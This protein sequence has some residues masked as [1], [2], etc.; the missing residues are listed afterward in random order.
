MFSKV[1]FQPHSYLG[2]GCQAE[3]V[4]T[5][6]VTSTAIKWFL[7]ARIV[8]RHSAQAIMRGSRAA[9]QTPDPPTVT[10]ACKSVVVAGDCEEE[11]K[12]EIGAVPGE[13]NWMAM[14]EETQTG[15]W[16]EGVELAAM[17]GTGCCPPHFKAP[18]S[19][20]LLKT[21]AIKIGGVCLRPTG[22]P[23]LFTLK[24]PPHTHTHCWILCSPFW[25]G[26]IGM[27]GGVQDWAL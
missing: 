23:F 27:A 21:Y 2:L 15:R 7:M 13:G 6:D 5:V 14:E 10:R 18:H 9:A 26:C 3:Q 1:H 19:F 17:A 25:C 22:A 20:P 8:G 16:Q 12:Q 4:T 11:R 24:S